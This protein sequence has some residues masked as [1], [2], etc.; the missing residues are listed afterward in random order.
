[1]IAP[2]TARSPWK[3]L[4]ELSLLAVATLVFV[5]VTARL[6]GLNVDDDTI[7][8]FNSQT[9]IWFTPYWWI[10]GQFGSLYL[11]WLRLL[12]ML[13]PLPYLQRYFFSWQVA[14]AMI[15]LL[16]PL[17]RVRNAWIY[18]VTVLTLPVL[19]V[20]FYVA[21]FA[22]A[23]PLLG[24]AWMLRRERSYSAA[25]VCG[26]LLCF[27]MQYARPEFGSAVHLG[28]AAALLAILLERPRGEQR[29]IA[30]WKLMALL[31]L[32]GLT[33]ETQRG[34]GL[35]RS[36]MSFEQHNNLRAR[37]AGVLPAGESPWESNYTQKLFGVDA[38]SNPP[39]THADISEFLKA[40][41]RLF[42]AH[43]LDNLRDWRSLAMLGFMLA[44]TAWPWLVRGARWLRP[45]SAMMILLCLPAAVGIVLIYP[46]DHYTISVAPAL[47][48]LLVQAWE[49]NGA[50][51]MTPL[52]VLLACV[53]LAGF[54]GLR[55]LRLNA[56]P[57]WAQ[58]YLQAGV[59]CAVDVDQAEL[60]SHPLSSW[61]VYEPIPNVLG[62]LSPH[63]INAT[64][65]EVATWPQ[66]QA[67]TKTAQP[68]WIQSNRETPGRVHASSAELDRWLRDEMGY[69]P[70][71][72]GHGT[73]WVIYTAGR[74]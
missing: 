55:R 27:V 15:A 48:L 73:D 72:C 71:P 26:T 10:H 6:I 40:N 56:E 20:G 46:R 47:I 49:L 62:Y 2:S 29:R 42:F 59:Q 69:T 31:L 14:A 33:V 4:L 5:R 13:H 16:P 57:Y 74:P 24:M 19:V 8:L 66:F 1:V 54:I 32:V 38:A 63:R 39:N 34:G 68:V 18:T 9:A 30:V 53:A 45:A 36:G 70:H 3:V 64:A 60:K 52:V 51:R 35:H 23:F 11:S 61:S 12:G 67:W 58:Q 22:A 41:P 43:I 21:L 25:M 65:A 28:A 44:L 17:L 50:R 37:E 7:Y